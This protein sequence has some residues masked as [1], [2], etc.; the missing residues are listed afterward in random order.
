[1]GARMTHLH[2]A[3]ENMLGN[4]QPDYANF[5]HGRLP[6]VVFNT[7]TVAHRCRR[8]ASA[9]SL[10]NQLVHSV[11]A[12]HPHGERSLLRD[13][14]AQSRASLMRAKAAM[15]VSRIHIVKYGSLNYHE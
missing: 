6:Q 12:H 3:P 5:Q 9:P 2:H 1:M 7:S 13:L 11:G 10:T 14:N 15:I 8:G 4:I